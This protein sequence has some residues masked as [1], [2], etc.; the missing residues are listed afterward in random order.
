MK[1]LQNVYFGMKNNILFTRKQ[2]FKNRNNELNNQL[3]NN[4][5]NIIIVL[6]KQNMLV[7]NISEIIKK[8]FDIDNKYNESDAD[9]PASLYIQHIPNVEDTANSQIINYITDKEIIDKFSKIYNLIVCNYRFINET[10]DIVE[11]LKKYR[12]KKLGD[13]YIMKKIDIKPDID[14]LVNSMIDNDKKIF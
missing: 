8:H 5:D 6:K 14:D 13:V 10:Y 2:M 7:D 4:M 12:N 11:Y 9:I 1:T 3:R